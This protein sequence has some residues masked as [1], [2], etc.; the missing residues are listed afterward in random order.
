MAFL[1]AYEE[2]H[3]AAGVARIARTMPAQAVARG[4]GRGGA[5]WAAVDG[6]PARADARGRLRGRRR[7]RRAGGGIVEESLHS[8]GRAIATMALVL[9][10]ELVVIGG[11]VAR[12]GDALIAPLRRRLEQ[13]ARLPPRLEASP[14][15]E[16]GVVLGAIRARAGRRR[17]AGARPPARSG[18]VPAVQN[19]HAMR[20][21]VREDY[22]RALAWLDG[23]AAFHTRLERFFTELRDPLV[24]LYGDDPRFPAQWARCWRRS[25]RAAAARDPPSLRALDHE[26]EITADWLQR[27]QAVGYVTYVDRFAGTLQRRARAP[28]VPARAGHQLPAPDAAPARAPGAERRRLRGR[29]LRAPWSPRSARWTT[30]AR[31][32]PTCAPPAWRCAS[33]SC[34][35]TPRGARVGARGA[36]RRRRE[37]RL[38]PDLPRPQRARRLRG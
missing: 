23:D 16:Q 21:E 9:N 17:A 14:L 7:R 2:E 12:A 31:S 26:R 29:G 1:G 33:T 4:E 20:P 25:P 22:E 8:A 36:R 35:T 5:L 28:A 38:L 27:E 18:I 32:P 15:A 13:M 19:V 30:C 10:P 37:A 11:G 6:D 3:G 34:S 24:A